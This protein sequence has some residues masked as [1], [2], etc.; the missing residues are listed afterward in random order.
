MGKLNI[1]HVSINIIEDW[2]V[3][4]P[5]TG[6]YTI[7]GTNTELI[8]KVFR[9]VSGAEQP[10]KGSVTISGKI[11]CD[12]ISTEADTVRRRLCGY[13]I[14]NV[15]LFMNMSVYKSIISNSNLSDNQND[16]DSLLTELELCNIK[17]RKIKN[18]DQLYRMKA[19]IARALVNH[20]E[21]LFVRDFDLNCDEETKNTIYSILKTLSKKMLVIMCSKD[22]DSVLLYSDGIVRCEDNEILNCNIFESA[23]DDIDESEVINDLDTHA[24]E[25][26]NIK[27]TILTKIKLLSVFK[28]HKFVITIVVILFTILMSLATFISMSEEKTYE[29]NSFFVM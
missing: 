4:F 21:V 28:S 22:M 10:E 1:K 6:L 7:T 18:L 11:F 26:K 25:D 29:E 20:P 27:T 8:E 24:V 17:D 3:E 2:S 13:V 19:L 14:Y 16:V 5:K 9:I 23:D 15:D 12:G